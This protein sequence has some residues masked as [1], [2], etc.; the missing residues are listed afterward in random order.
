MAKLTLL[1]P[2]A[3]GPRTTLARLVAARRSYQTRRTR[4]EPPDRWRRLWVRNAAG[5]PSRGVWRRIIADGKV[6]MTRSDVKAR[7]LEAKRQVGMPWREIAGKIGKGSPVFYTASTTSW[8]VTSPKWVRAN[9]SRTDKIV[10]QSSNSPMPL[11]P[12]NEEL[13]GV[14]LL[15]AR[16]SLD[17]ARAAIANNQVTKEEGERIHKTA[18]D[19]LRPSGDSPGWCLMARFPLIY[20]EPAGW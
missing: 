19:I 3:C 14:D 15:T 17:A 4:L 9:S 13:L 2:K 5:A 7:I 1:P 18:A 12:P 11:Q 16:N 8:P 20:G 10:L 6:L